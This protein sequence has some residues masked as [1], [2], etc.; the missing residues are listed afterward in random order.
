MASLTV[1]TGTLAGKRV[2]IRS[3]RLV[4]GRSASAHLV[5]PTESVSSRHCAIMP[6]GGRYVLQDTDSTNGTRL[7]GAPVREA[8]L[9]QG[10]LISVGDVD[11]R[12]E[13]EG[14]Q[15]ATVSLP[16]FSARR[17]GR[18]RRV[19]VWGGLGVV[20]LIAFVVFLLRLT[21]HL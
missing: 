21:G 6:R 10:D 18:A 1:E 11:L 4:I 8:R 20:L 13:D 7:N 15:D 19:A 12:F 16:A 14:A 2:E 3:D 17:S 9:K 5:L